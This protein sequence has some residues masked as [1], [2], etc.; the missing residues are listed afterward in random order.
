VTLT[1]RFAR[2]AKLKKSK[3]ERRIHM[4]K[5]YRWSKK[6]GRWVLIDYGVKNKVD[7]YIKQGYVVFKALGRL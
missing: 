3:Y 1:G 4:V 6:K 5:L 7:E 2:Q